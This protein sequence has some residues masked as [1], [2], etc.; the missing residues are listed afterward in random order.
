M[1]NLVI[2]NT[3]QLSYYFPREY[4]K[5]SSRDID[6]LRIKR[7]FY[8]RIYLCFA[9]QK[10]YLDMDIS[11]FSKINYDYTLFLIEELL[12]NCNNIVIYSTAEL[13]NNYDGPI[14]LS[15]A[16]NYNYSHY[17]KSKEMISNTIL[18][19]T[20]YKKV[21]II[22]PFNFNSIY[23]KG[24][25]L[26][27]KVYKSIVDNQ[28]ITIGDVDFYR[29]IIHPQNIVNESINAS[30][31]KIIGSGY[32]YNIKNFIIDLYQMTNKNFDDYVTINSDLNLKN[33]RKN[34]FSLTKYSNY[35]ELLQLSLK[36]INEYRTS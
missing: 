21:I 15:M 28:N 36:D 16:Y 18:N 7:F 2:G 22:Y 29:D 20:K 19:S 8:D 31:H 23:R 35:N 27:G 33:K 12:S 5:V 32:L 34:Y 13:W 24:N 17:I 26:F 4:I 25:F 10:T 6:L 11:S 3:S 9:E 30:D 1:N 14:C